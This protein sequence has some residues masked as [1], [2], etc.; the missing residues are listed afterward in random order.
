MNKPKGKV[1]YDLE[2]VCQYMVSLGHTVEELDAFRE[3]IWSTSDGEL[4]YLSTEDVPYTS[5]IRYVLSELGTQNGTNRNGTKFL[6]IS[7]LV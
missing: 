3:Y 1:V 7:L 4:V 6:E 2:V 5:L